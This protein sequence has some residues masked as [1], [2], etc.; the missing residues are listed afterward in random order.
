MNIAST[1]C[2]VVD[3]QVLDIRRQLSAMDTL[4][5]SDSTHKHIPIENRKLTVS[6]RF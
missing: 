1:Y 5:L 6:D 3:L 2:M 4:H